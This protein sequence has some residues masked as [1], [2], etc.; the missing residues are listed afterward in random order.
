[1][2][3]RLFITHNVVILL[4]LMSLCYCQ[5]QSPDND[6]KQTSGIPTPSQA[7][8]HVVELDKGGMFFLFW[9]FDEERITFEVH[10]RTHGWVGLGFTNNGRM[11]GSDVVVGW[12]KDGVTYFKVSQILVIMRCHII[13]SSISIKCFCFWL[14]FASMLPFQ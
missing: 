1:M 10:V 8:P 13:L 11:E 9:E 7:Y 3:N 4:S 2:R 12:I 14:L 6:T 5:N